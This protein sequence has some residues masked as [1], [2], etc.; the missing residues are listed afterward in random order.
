MSERKLKS[1]RKQM[2]KV[3]NEIMNEFLNG[4]KEVGLLL[5]LKF[6]FKLLFTNFR[7]FDKKEVTK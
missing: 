3:K 1:L 4:L 6:C 5:K 7:L 2:K